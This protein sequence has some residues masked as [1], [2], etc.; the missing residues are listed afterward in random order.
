M[1]TILFYSHELSSLAYRMLTRSRRSVPTD[2]RLI[3]RLADI[4]PT[5]L[6][7][8]RLTSVGRF[9]GQ[10]YLIFINVKNTR[11]KN[12]NLYDHKKCLVPSRTC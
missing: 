4:G 1:L 7:N 6:N 9:G 12:Y 3:I 11:K 8:I 5:T 2:R 10:I